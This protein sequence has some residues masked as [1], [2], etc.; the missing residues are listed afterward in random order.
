M[1]LG[2]LAAGAT[3]LALSLA[4]VPSVASAAESG[5]SNEDYFMIMQAKNP[6]ASGV[7]PEGFSV[8]AYTANLT[9]TRNGNPVDTKQVHYGDQIVVTTGKPTLADESEHDWKEPFS[10]KQTLK[11]HSGFTSDPTPPVGEKYLW[12][13]TG[14]V[15]T[16]E[17]K[18]VAP[19][20]E[21]KFTYTVDCK[22]KPGERF[23]FLDARYDKTVKDTAPTRYGSYYDDAHNVA[24]LS[25][26][27]NDPEGAAK[28]AADGKAKP[29][30]DSQPAADQSALDQKASDFDDKQYGDNLTRPALANRTLIKDQYLKDID[31]LLKQDAQKY[32]PLEPY[33]K[34]ISDALA[35]ADK[36]INDAKDPLSDSATKNAMA[37][38]RRAY[39]NA[40]LQA[41][42]IQNPELAEQYQALQRLYYQAKTSGNSQLVN[43]VTEIQ[44][45]L[46]KAWPAW[47]SPDS[48]AANTYSYMVI[49]AENK[50]LA[51]FAKTVNAQIK[52]LKA[53]LAQKGG[54]TGSNNDKQ[55]MPKPANKPQQGSL[56]R[57]G[58]IALLV[59]ALAETLVAAGSGITYLSRRSKQ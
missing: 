40:W 29:G 23:A 54:N 24:L 3:A 31:K 34:Q 51:G 15:N 56:A 27:I 35:A 16:S 8:Y 5:L 50:D 17:T 7:F 49:N 32:A 55:V 46:N 28:C 45:A 21:G 20:E 37:K 33:K 6:P 47:F 19:T 59:S 22:L 9:A 42:K 48:T 2:K 26:T 57:T 58:A 44:S 13:P 41:L 36:A 25:F 1:K 4:L 10:T 14:V 39:L 53:Q 11:I 18:T 12:E 52:T 30:K 38:F 43:E